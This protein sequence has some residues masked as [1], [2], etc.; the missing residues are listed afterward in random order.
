MQLITFLLRENSFCSRVRFSLF[1]SREKRKKLS[2]D[3]G[4]RW[5]RC[6]NKTRF[7]LLCYRARYA[8]TGTRT[9]GERKCCFS[10]FCFFSV[11]KS[12]SMLSETL[13]SFP[14]LPSHQHFLTFFS[15]P[16]IFLVSSSEKK[17]QTRQRTHAQHEREKRVAVK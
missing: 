9:H 15:S 5:A 17:T 7:F 6:E 16:V 3:D 8:H 11:L 12:W 1:G 10:S 4:I 2:D 14:S 13:Y